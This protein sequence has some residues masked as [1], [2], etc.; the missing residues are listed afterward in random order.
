MY[1]CFS[2]LQEGVFMWQL[3][4]NNEKCRFLRKHTNDL[5]TVPSTMDLEYNPILRDEDVT[6]YRKDDHSP[7]ILIQK[8]W[9]DRGLWETT[10]WKWEEQ[11]N[12]NQRLHK[13]HTEMMS[14]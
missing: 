7:Q 8:G 14:M 10:Y 11:I 6:F 3:I 2:K 1:S 13:I 9:N 5:F 4:S 12:N